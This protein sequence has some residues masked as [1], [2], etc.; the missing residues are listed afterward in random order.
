M[1]SLSKITNHRIFRK[2]TVGEAAILI[3]LVVFL[4]KIVGYFRDVLI[5]KYFGA[6]GQ[7]DAFLIALLIP[8]IVMG[9]ISCGLS[10]L[11]IPVYLEKKEKLVIWLG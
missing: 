4:A 1:I 3:T 8:S 10:T 5:A 7:T 9:I 2:Q 11:I 6:S